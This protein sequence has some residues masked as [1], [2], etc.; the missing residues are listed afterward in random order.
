MNHD[1]RRTFL[2]CSTTSLA[3]GALTTV[4]GCNETAPAAAPPA[5]AD[6]KRYKAAFS[7]A[8]LKATWCAHGMDTVKWWG[9]RLGIDVTIYDS[10][11][12]IDKQRQD[13]E[14]MAT[15]DWDFVAIQAYAI[16]TLEE[17]VKRL[18][19]RGIPV[20]D[21]DTRIV[22]EG[23]DIGLWTFMTPDHEKLAEQATEMICQAMGGKGKIVHTQGALA[24]SGAQLRAKG[25][26]NVVAKYPDIEVIDE[27]PGDWDINKVGKIW[28][29]LLVKFDQIDGAFCHNDDMAMAAV[30]AIKRS[31]KDRKIIFGSIDAQE[32]GINGV[33]NGDLICSAMNA[34]GRIHLTAL[35]VGYFA[36]AQNQQKSEVP[37]FMIIDNPV[38]T[39]D[40]AAG[41]K[42]LM[43]NRMI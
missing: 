1:S 8:G 7:N 14:D 24:H 16:K 39:K 28:D 10:Q 4:F 42:Y 13:I 41:F 3:L 11:L 22:P 33:M 26:R 9:D 25:F 43:E 17:P 37:P 31:G 38:V 20:I 32:Q 30:R 23:E 2:Q 19:D 6:G 18:I 5:S 36:C 27:Q 35:M 15:K 34:A 29:D 40:N 12:N 21:F